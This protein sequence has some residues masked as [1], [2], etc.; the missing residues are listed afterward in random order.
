MDFDSEIRNAAF[1][2]LLEQKNILGD[3]FPR[4]LLE[5]GFLFDGIK[6]ALVS[7]QGIFKPRMMDFPLSITTTPKGPY[8]DSFSNDGLLLYRY[9]G[10]DPNHK[11]NVGLRTAFKKGLPLVYFHGIVPGQYLAVWPVYITGD[12]PTNLLFNVAVDDMQNLSLGEDLPLVAEDSISR[13]KYL[14]VS[15]KQRLHQRTFR[16]RVLEAYKTSCAFCSLRH[17]ELLDAA[18]IIP[19]REPDSKPIISNGMALCKLHHAAY[20]SFIIGVTPDY[21]IQVRRDILKEVDGPLLQY[22]LK[23]LHNEKLS[24]PTSRKL[25]P[26]KENLEWR[27]DRFK[28]VA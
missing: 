26:G 11:D 28:K 19:D 16:E 14:T 23:N 22:G 9:R 12:D 10:S 3:V 6:I 18:H 24:L 7:P 15:V 2:W 17:R 21:K 25:W 8:N 5:N 4:K 27:F 1:N 20:D 13:R